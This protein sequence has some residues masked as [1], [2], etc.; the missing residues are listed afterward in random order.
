MGLELR[1]YRHDQSGSCV[2]L[3]AGDGAGDALMD[4]HQALLG[5]ALEVI[6][7]DKDRQWI[8]AYGAGEEQAEGLVF[9]PLDFC[10]AAVGGCRR[11]RW[12]GLW[13]LLPLPPG[14]CPLGEVGF[15]AMVQLGY[16]PQGL[17]EPP[18]CPLPQAPG[19]NTARSSLA[20]ASQRW[21]TDRLSASALRGARS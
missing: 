9:G 4:L 20:W 3:G 8:T 7:D 17:L 10:S 12:A 18:L 21:S 2:V 11:C 19:H 13:L 15:D 16:H 6:A 1:G 14:V 5:A